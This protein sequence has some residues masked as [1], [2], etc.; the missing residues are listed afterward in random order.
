MRLT[1]LDIRKQE[2]T[3][4]F[5]GYDADE[6]NA[7][8]QMVSSQWDEILDDSRRKDEK[9]RDLENKMVHYEKVEEAL[10]EALQTA[11]ETS[12]KA[13]QNAEDKARLI[14]DEAERRAEDIKR[15]AEQDRYQIKRETAK[16][17]GR[18]SEIVTRLRAF[19]MSEMELLARFEGD[20]PVGFI[21]LLPAEERRMR[22][23]PLDTHSPDERSESR[24]PAQQE[25]GGE[26]RGRHRE[27][28]G[29]PET[30]RREP[31]TSRSE[32]E[33]SFSPMPTFAQA[34]DYH[35][36]EA[37]EDSAER[38]GG[39]AF[40]GP[41]AEESAGDRRE[42]GS[43]DE[44][45]M[46]ETFAEEE[47]DTYEDE[48]YDEGGVAFESE[49]AHRPDADEPPVENRNAPEQARTEEV[50]QGPGW[51]ARTVISQPAEQRASRPEDQPQRGEEQ[52]NATSTRT[53]SDEIE[54]I[55]RI[56]S[57]LD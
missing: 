21:K 48:W 33:T 40:A 45:Q 18:R 36:E 20:D 22:Q 37:A 27:G 57:D 9:I 3:R 19:L 10:Q 47:A 24:G 17:S 1:S 4:G 16:L 32:P 55:R 11:R 41:P 49:A 23:I 51:T 56:L 2:F 34:Q 7:F 46:R 28:R 35:G 44:Y 52:G 50:I 38:M 5:R 13:L 8:L 54:K 26:N 25:L 31:E 15:D 12:R 6:V 39:G 53:S 42:Q 30:S 14:V 43:S 29:E